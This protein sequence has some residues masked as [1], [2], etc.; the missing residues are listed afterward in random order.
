MSQ[1]LSLDDP[2]VIKVKRIFEANKI[3]YNRGDHKGVLTFDELFTLFSDPANTFAKIGKLDKTCKQNMSVKYA[4]YFAPL[5]PIDLETGMGRRKAARQLR[6]QN[7]FHPE[8]PAG[9][10]ANLIKEKQIQL[11]VNGISQA[12]GPAKPMWHYV[13]INDNLIFVAI[14]KQ[15]TPQPHTIRKYFRF[16]LSNKT[17]AKVEFVCFITMCSS[18]P[19][20]YILSKKDFSHHN[21]RSNVYYIPDPESPKIG[22]GANPLINWGFHKNNWALLDQNAK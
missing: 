16:S 7:N 18:G 9:L 14:C 12:S 4:T 2:E 11:N 22:Y 5:F 3:S 10:L 20:V 1:L 6:W 19:D 15:S 13:K 21:S 8:S 17:L